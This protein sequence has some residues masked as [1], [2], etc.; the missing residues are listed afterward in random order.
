MSV[1]HI[2]E[3]E[4][5]SEAHKRPVPDHAETS[6]LDRKIEQMLEAEMAKGLITSFTEDFNKLMQRLETGITAERAAMDKLRQ[7]LR[8]I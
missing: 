4:V 7:R 5:Q 3:D 2:Q 8:A 1:T 6:A